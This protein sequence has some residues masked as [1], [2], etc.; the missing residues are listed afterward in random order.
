MVRLDSDTGTRRVRSG[1]LDIRQ[2]CSKDES[3]SAGISRH[4]FNIP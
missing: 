2:G 1:D 4:T 3:L